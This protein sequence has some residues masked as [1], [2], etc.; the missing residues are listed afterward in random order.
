METVFQLVGFTVLPWWAAMILAP[1]WRWTTRLVSSPLIVVPPLAIYAVLVLPRLAA[2]LPAVASPELGVIAA[3]L[4][5]PT[6]TTI[7][8]AHFLAFDL[9][10]GRWIF[11]DARE[12]ALSP[13]LVSPL[14]LATFLVGPIGLLGYLALRSALTR[15]GGDS[16]AAGPWPPPA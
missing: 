5:T 12:R 6:G 14:L 4:G 3:S 9:F 1:R 13:W 11:L 15:R 7:A 8:W 2:I 10:V 16:S